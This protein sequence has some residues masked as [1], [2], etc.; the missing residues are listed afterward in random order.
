MTAG[1]SVVVACHSED[2]WLL[3]LEAI[4]SIRRQS[5]APA[6]TIVVVDH[7]PALLARLRRH[8]PS[9]TVVPNAGARGASGARNTGAELATGAHLAF[10]DDDARADPQWLERLVAPLKDPVIAGVAGRVDPLWETHRP[11]W[12]PEEFDWVVGASYRGM[13]LAAAPVRNG[14]GESMAVRTSDFLAVGGFRS[15]FGKLGERSRPEDTDLCIRLSEH[16]G[17]PWLYEPAAAVQHFV[18]RARSTFGFYLRRTFAE[19]RGKAELA[20]LVSASAALGTER[21]YALR[22]LPRGAAAHLAAAART[23][24]AGELGKAACIGIGLGWTA[25]GYAI[26]RAGAAARRRPSPTAANSAGAAARVAA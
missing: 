8:A 26:G 9:A 24:A 2:R 14:W 12:F 25:A 1:A 20:S 16:V 6:E 3:I 10:L 13:P 17:G 7:N 19:G 22:V 11:A 5:M 21:G 15:G 18:P 23:R 4:D